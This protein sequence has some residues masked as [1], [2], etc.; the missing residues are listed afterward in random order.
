MAALLQHLHEAVEAFHHLPSAVVADDE[1]HAQLGMLLQV[2]ELPG[3]EVGDEVA[4]VAERAAH[5]Q[6]VEPLGQVVQREPEQREAQ[7][8]RHRGGNLPHPVLQERRSRTGKMHVAARDEGRIERRVVAVA[9][10]ADGLVADG[11]HAGL[12]IACHLTAADALNDALRL[13]KVGG[14]GLPVVNAVTGHLVPLVHDALHHVGSL[15]GKV[16]R[17]EERGPHTVLPEYVEDAARAFARHAHP[18]L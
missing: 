8:G 4:V 10:L 5:Q 6:M 15:F 14:L 9:R 18:L 16:S 11:E 17:A 3:M 7:P 12:A 13:G 2:V 1:G